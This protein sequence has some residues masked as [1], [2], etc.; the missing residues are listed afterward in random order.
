MNVEV[1]SHNIRAVDATDV[2]SFVYHADV[3]AS[4]WIRVVGIKA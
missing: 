1:E 3:Q 4:Q 2:S